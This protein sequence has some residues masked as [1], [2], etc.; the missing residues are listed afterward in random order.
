MYILII[1][2]CFIDSDL[3]SVVAGSTGHTSG[4]HAP[5]TENA[6]GSKVNSHQRH[7]SE[8]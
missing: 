5:K 4:C 6:R 1:Y 2:N 8:Q 7:E 3:S